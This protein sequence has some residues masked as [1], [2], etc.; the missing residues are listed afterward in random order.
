MARGVNKNTTL[1]TILYMVGAVKE[2]DLTDSSAKLVGG[3]VNTAND[4]I[5][6]S[7]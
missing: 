4:V 2:D 7:L 5:L 6:V 3:R 1:L